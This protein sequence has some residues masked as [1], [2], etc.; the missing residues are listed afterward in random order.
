MVQDETYLP[1][2]LPVVEAFKGGSELDATRPNGH[3]P[4][5]RTR[6]I[7]LSAFGD[8]TGLGGFRLHPENHGRAVRCGVPLLQEDDPILALFFAVRH[9]D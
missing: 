9:F 3:A 1:T 8:Q 2:Y 5:T 4:Q 6:P 7:D